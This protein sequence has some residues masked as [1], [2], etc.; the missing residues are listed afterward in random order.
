MLQFSPASAAAT[1]WIR[2]IVR[3]AERGGDADAD[4]VVQHE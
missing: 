2:S 4:E 1:D 3:G